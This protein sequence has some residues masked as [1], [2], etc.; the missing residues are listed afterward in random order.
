MNE[1]NQCF[2]GSGQP[3][4]QIGEKCRHYRFGDCILGPDCALQMDNKP[5]VSFDGGCFKRGAK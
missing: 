5:N 4:G 2:E 1:V 3:Y